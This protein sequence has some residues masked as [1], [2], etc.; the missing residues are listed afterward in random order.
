MAWNCQWVFFIDKQFFI[1]E[2]LIVLIFIRNLEIAFTAYESG[3]GTYGND[4]I[5]VFN[6]VSINLG[7]GFDV[8]TGT[9]VAPV[10]GTYFF[11]L[12]NTF[13]QYIQHLYESKH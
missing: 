10:N 1:C 12:V 4:Q 6:T 8:T 9:F 2:I 7:N 3:P 11:S 13:Q 5:I